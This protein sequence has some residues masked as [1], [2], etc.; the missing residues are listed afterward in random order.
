MSKQLKG[1]KHDKGKVRFSLLPFDGLTEVAKVFE[2]GAKKY[3]RNNWK[4]GLQYSRLVDATFRHLMAVVQKQDVDPESGHLHAAHAVANLLM[5]L[6]FMQSGGGH[7]D[8]WS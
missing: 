3:G 4:R 2:F 1:I 7:D 6:S 8:R 5:L